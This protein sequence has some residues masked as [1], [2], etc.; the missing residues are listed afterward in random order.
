MKLPVAHSK[1]S[2]RG[3]AL[4]LAMIV[5]LILSTLAVAMISTTHTDGVTSANYRLVTQARF[6]AEAG[7]QIVTNW[8]KYSLASPTGTTGLDMTK[9]PLK[10]TSGNFIILCSVSTGAVCAADST[11]TAN[12]PADAAQQT[13]FNTRIANINAGA[14]AGVQ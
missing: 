5:I 7:A 2:E 11:K 1:P 8:L 3:V 4:I 6:T 14:V 9:Y 12:Y 10:D 13:A